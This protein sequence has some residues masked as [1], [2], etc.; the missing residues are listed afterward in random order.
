M[1]ENGSGPAQQP[2][3]LPQDSI[4]PPQAPQYL[5]YAIAGMVPY[6]SAR[7]RA[8]V[9]IGLLWAAVVLQLLHVWPQL[10]TVSEL[11]A[12]TLA[13]SAEQVAKH[14]SRSDPFES[15][16][17]R[18][19]V[20][21]F[22][23]TGLLLILYVVWWMMWVHRTYR[24]LRPLGAEGLRYSPGWAVAYYFIPIL[25]LFR[26]C[27]VMRETWRASDRG[28]TAWASARAPSLIAAWWTVFLVSV[29]V[30]LGQGVTEVVHEGNPRVLYAMS[31]LGLGV[32]LLD[33]VTFLLEIWLVKS[34]TGLQ[35][36]RADALLP[37]PFAA[38][39]GPRGLSAGGEAPVHRFRE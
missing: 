24:N 22:S 17:A 2:P 15:T 18:P 31:W 32:L 21:L 27:Q 25:N 13:T 9:L 29:F 11:R 39:A 12:A 23:L 8:R 38:P 14:L 28:G 5:G 4:A 37:V 7:P 36:A 6:A 26:P 1:T 35:E 33:A 16:S 30:S 20:V 19:F 10:H 3:P 34:L